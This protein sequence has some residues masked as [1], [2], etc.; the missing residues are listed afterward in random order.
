MTI[1]QVVGTPWAQASERV[2]QTDEDY[3]VEHGDDVIDATGAITIT[4]PA[5]P[6][7]G[8]KHRILAATDVVTLNGN[9]NS[10]LNPSTGTSTL[11]TIPRATYVVDAGIYV[12]V[13]FSTESVWVPSYVETTSIHF[14]CGNVATGNL[15]VAAPATPAAASMAF[16]GQLNIAHARTI[17]AIHLHLIET[18]SAGDLVIEVYRRRSGAFTLLATLTLSSADGDFA[19]AAVVP[20][21][22][23]ARL[24]PGDYLYAQPLDKT[25]V[26]NGANGMTI[27]VHFQN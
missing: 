27:D 16:F 14:R 23:L 15:V 7:V 4:L 24:Q 1:R 9:G 12:D 3:L 25:L 13:T 18:G 26:T 8:E 10:I 21:G 11:N 17:A 6:Q 19:T 2:I 22:A 5:S 20:A